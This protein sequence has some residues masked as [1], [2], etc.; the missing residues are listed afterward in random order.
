[1]IFKQFPIFENV[2]DEMLEDLA[3]RCSWRTI[4]SGRQIILA[5]EASS[6]VYFITEGKVKVLLYSADEGRE[7][8][9][10]EFGLYEMFGELS[11]IDGLPRSATVEAEEECRLA[12]LSQEQF[13]RLLQEHSDFAFAVL[14]QLASQV[15]RLSERV[16]EFSTLTVHSRILAELLRLAVPVPGKR[17][18]ALISH[19]P[20]REDFAARLSTTR[21]QVSRAITKMAKDG[22]LQREGKKS[23]RI[24]DLERLRKLASKAKGE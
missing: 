14:K 9:F 13:R 12:V 3:A 7:V 22:I 10:T 24:I 8:H 6:D 11:A 2:R 4:R 5:K 16:F 1:M 18:Q 21:E 20:P 17:G 19:V 23:I 15:R